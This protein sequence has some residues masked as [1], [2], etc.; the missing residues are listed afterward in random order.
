MFLMANWLLKALTFLKRK[1]DP[2]FQKDL[3]HNLPLP[4]EVKILPIQSLKHNSIFNNSYYC[5]IL[6]LKGQTDRLQAG[7]RRF[8]KRKR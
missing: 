8:L 2:H 5:F 4:Q 1:S 3:M 7:G 6:V